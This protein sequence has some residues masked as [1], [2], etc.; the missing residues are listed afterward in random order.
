MPEYLYKAIDESG[1]HHTGTV[2]SIDSK[3]AAVD[4]RRKQLYLVQMKPKLKS[5]WTREFEVLRPKI[6]R[7]DLVVFCRQLATLVRAGISIVEA[8]DILHQQISDRHFKKVLADIRDDLKEG[9]SLSAALASQDALP[10]LFKN[11]VRAGEVSGT[12]DEVLEKVAVYLEKEFYTREKVKSAMIYPAVIGL[13]SLVVVTFL[14]ISVVPTFV[15]IFAQQGRIL[16]LPT[17]FVLGASEFLQSY[18]LTI[19]AVACGAFILFRAWVR[20]PNGRYKWHWFLLKLP[21]FGIVLQKAVIARFSRTFA[22]LV[23][24]AVPILKSIDLVTEVVDNEVIARD[25]RASRESLQQGNTL[26]GPITK[27]W[28]FPP[29][30]AQ[31]IQIGEKTGNLDEMM[32]K[33]AD[34]YERD[35]EMVVDRLKAL[36]EPIMILILAGVVGSIIM[37]VLLPTFDLIQNYR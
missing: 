19:L 21:V 24:S 27:S 6:K 7:K 32:N 26:S 25:L 13:I 23:A 35:V 34:F 8:I 15:Q 37:A 16:P 30:V 28:V 17:R 9:K 18:F 20:T 31:M 3:Q 4:L 5:I 10:M 1:K 33:I 14:L 29:L 36:I 12:L 2:L 11:M 22:S